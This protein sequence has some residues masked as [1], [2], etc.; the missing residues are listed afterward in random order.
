MLWEKSVTMVTEKE[1]VATGEGGNGILVEYGH[2]RSF[3]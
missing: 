2:A 3:C 1:Y